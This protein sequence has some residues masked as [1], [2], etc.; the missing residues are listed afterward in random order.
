V[1]AK[2]GDELTVRGRLVGDEER[3]GEIIEVHGADGAPP[4]LV[5]WRDD[6]ESVFFP[7]SDTV[8]EHRPAGDRD[9]DGV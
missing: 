9:R 5:R 4:Y 6:H 1:H 2:A 7:S 3:H 8:V